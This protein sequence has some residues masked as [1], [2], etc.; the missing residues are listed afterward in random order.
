MHMKNGMECKDQIVELPNHKMLGQ[1]ISVLMPIIHQGDLFLSYMISS[2]NRY[3][4]RVPKI[5]DFDTI[6]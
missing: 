6:Y 3:F 5:Y 1:A 4:L 2:T